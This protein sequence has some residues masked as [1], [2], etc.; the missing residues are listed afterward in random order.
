[1]I[2]EWG[3]MLAV[4]LLF[5]PDSLGIECFFQGNATITAVDAQGRNYISDIVS[6][7]GRSTS[8]FL[9]DVHKKNVGDIWVR[10]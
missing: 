2:Q 1:M 8:G 7:C 4:R 3:Y 6:L 10:K 5:L 9:T